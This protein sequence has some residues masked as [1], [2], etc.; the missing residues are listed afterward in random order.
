MISSMQVPPIHAPDPLPA[1]RRFAYCWLLL[2]T[3]LVI[4][5]RLLPE[6]FPRG[7]LSPLL[8]VVHAAL[9]ALYLRVSW[10]QQRL[11]PAY[12]LIALIFAAF[13]SQ[14]I[15]LFYLRLELNSLQGDP[16]TLGNIIGIAHWLLLWPT[17][18]VVL[19]WKY[20]LRQIVG[21]TVA[22]TLFNLG[23]AWF[24]FRGVLPLGPDALLAF[25]FLAAAMLTI[26]YFARLL[27]SAEQQQR[28]ALQAANHQLVQAASTLEQ[29]TISRERN[30][31]A[32]ELHDT[33]AHTLSGLAVQLETARAYGERDP[34][35]TQRLLSDAL[36]NTRTGLHETRRALQS[37]RASPLEDLG[38]GLAIRA[39]AH[40]AAER[41]DLHVSIQLSSDLDRLDP[42]HAQGVYRI[43]QEAI[44]NVVR[45]AQARHLWVELR[46]APLYVCI[47]DD[48]RG[49]TPTSVPPRA[50]YGIIGMHERAA[51]IG[52]T[53]E[54]TSADQCGTTVLVRS[55]EQPR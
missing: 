41:A 52:A 53:L 30:A 1:L 3:L 24:L 17:V 46:S 22:L 42:L 6:L 35:V 14:A 32:R 2:I 15:L 39:L 13:G 38:L 23:L 37:L 16:A 29:L 7:W 8:Y 9:L 28:H 33:L 19:G 34:Q 21:F 48:G 50:H 55:L 4:G 51:L 47:R 27:S 36:S 26:S 45:H 40:S 49:F 25:G 54:I 18:A 43:A 11:G 20:P 44:S 31:M 12:L 10:L 5:P